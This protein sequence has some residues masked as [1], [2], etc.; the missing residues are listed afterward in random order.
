MNPKALMGFLALRLLA[1]SALS[2]VLHDA[3]WYASFRQAIC[4]WLHNQTCITSR[5][6]SLLVLLGKRVAA[7]VS[8][9][10]VKLRNTVVVNTLDDLRLGKFIV[11]LGQFSL[12]FVIGFEMAADHNG[13]ACEQPYDDDKAEQS[14]Y[15]R[16]Y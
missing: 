9:V 12:G 11:A 4:R 7:L 3:K 5:I 1:A 8:V 2:V 14:R 15:C 13:N 10:V 6:F 16:A